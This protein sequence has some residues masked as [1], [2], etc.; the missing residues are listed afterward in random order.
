MN[1]NYEIAHPY[2]LF[3]GDADDDLAAK[4]AR[5]ILQWRP[6]W[7]L[8]QFRLEG[9]NTSLGIADL[10]LEEAA[11]KGVKT[12]VVGVANRGGVVSKDW[13]PTLLEALD[14]G[15]DL[16]SGLHQRLIDLPELHA[17]AAETGRK[18]FDVRHPP[19]EF[20][21]AN[22]K[23][24]P[25]KRLLTVGTDASVGKMYTTLALEAALKARGKPCSFRA[26]GQTGIFIAGSGVS[27]DAVVAD[28]I[29]GATEWLTPDNAPE[30]WDLIEGQGSLFHPSFAGVTLG[31]IHGAQP[32]ALVLCHEPTRAHMRGL[33][34]QPLPDLRTCLDANLEAATLTN[35]KVRAVGISINTHA[36]DAQAA[37]KLLAE[38]AEAFGLPCVDPVRGGVEPIADQLW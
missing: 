22:G 18:L 28:F 8:G 29:S 14:R 12:L 10:S 16:A 37:D 13:M 33:P 5:G 17:R 26:T 23:K 1:G 24:R 20:S 3:L 34:G 27:V 38:T 36:L 19:R 9:C 2:I 30:H 11:A 21:V 7:C 6:A 15:M 4:T 32:D 31:L 35:P 25:G